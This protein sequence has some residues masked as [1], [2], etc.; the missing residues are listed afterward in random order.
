MIMGEQANKIGK[1]LKDLENT[2]FRDLVGMNLLE[3][4]KF[5]VVESINMTNKHMDWIY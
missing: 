1:N 2:Y 5:S 3:I 4:Q